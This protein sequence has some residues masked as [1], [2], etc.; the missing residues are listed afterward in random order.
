MLRGDLKELEAINGWLL[1]RTHTEMMQLA[2]AA[3]LMVAAVSSLL[4]ALTSVGTD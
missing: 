3:A 1:A 4:I 2:I